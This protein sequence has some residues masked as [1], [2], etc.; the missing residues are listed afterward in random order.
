MYKRFIFVYIFLGLVLLV[1][2]QNK[3]G[4]VIEKIDA[5]ALGRPL[6]YI[7]IDTDKDKIS[8]ACIF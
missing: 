2:S 8:D 6:S 4:V 3:T 5:N 1:F 7:F